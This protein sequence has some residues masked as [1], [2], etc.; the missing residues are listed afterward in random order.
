[1]R[2]VLLYYILLGI[3]V[4]AKKFDYF[5]SPL[6]NHASTTNDISTIP[7]NKVNKQATINAAR[8]RAAVQKY[9]KA[10]K[11]ANGL[12]KTKKT[13]IKAQPQIR[14]K[15]SAFGNNILSLKVTYY[16]ITIY[17]NYQTKTLSQKPYH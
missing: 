4:T 3:H 12:K 2:V 1:M 7:P 15:K 16:C 6:F 13:W 11:G 14:T 17:Y 10:A 8:A 5:K 9:A